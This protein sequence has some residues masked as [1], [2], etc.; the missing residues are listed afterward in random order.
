VRKTDGKTDRFEE[1]G[2]G[3]RTRIKWI[4]K[5]QEGKVWTETNLGE[6]RPSGRP[7]RAMKWGNFVATEE[8]I[9]VSRTLLHGVLFRSTYSFYGFHAFHEYIS[10]KMLRNHKEQFNQNQVLLYSFSYNRQS[11]TIR[12]QPEVT[13]AFPVPPLDSFLFDVS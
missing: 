12:E 5:K 1:L 6:D 2:L 10:S 9:S 4:L 3:G 13:N 8:P 11:C 7:S